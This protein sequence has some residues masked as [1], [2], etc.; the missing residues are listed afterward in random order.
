MKRIST[1]FSMVLFTMFVNAQSINET[2]ESYS[3]LSQLT[4]KCWSFTGVGLSTTSG[5]MSSKSLQVIP[6]TSAGGSANSNTAEIVTPYINLQAGTALTFKIKLSND[7]ST[8][9]D[10]TVQVRTL[11]FAGVYSSVLATVT[12]DKNSTSA[13]AHTV[14][15]AIN[16]TS[17]QKLV[18]NI[19]GNGDGN[20]WLFIDD[21]IYASTFI[22]NAPY[23]CSS[24]AVPIILPVKLL[25]FSGNIANQK[26]KLQWTVAEN[27]KGEHF[28]IEKSADGKDFKS[29][30]LVF[31]TEKAGTEHYSYSEASEASATYFRLKVVNKDNSISYSKVVLLKTGNEM[32][33][34]NLS[35]VQ[36]PVEGNLSLQYNV[37]TAGVQKVV[38]Y[39]AAG[40]KVFA[41][42]INLQKGINVVSLPLNGS[43]K[44]GIYVLE[45]SNERDR[46]TARV[47]K[48]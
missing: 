12:F 32:M 31:T 18:L 20:T 26:L 24:Y 45:V 37:V 5:I 33:S 28:K 19:T 34:S 23:G 39:N 9:A 10:R 1:L 17:I 16:A 36:N 6:T 38:I 7:L 48:K 27:E 42:Q 21:F 30:G 47:V 29:I 46:A 43:V 41:T 2:F 3:S 44:A 15:V 22:Y 8:Q 4:N 35:I 13:S 25:S 40:S 11:S 14:A